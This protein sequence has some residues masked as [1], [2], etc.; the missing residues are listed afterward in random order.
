MLRD[1][2]RELETS[3][4]HKL[5]FILTGTE[6]PELYGAHGYGYTGI[7]EAQP[8]PRPTEA[9]EPVS[10]SNRRRRARG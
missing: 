10:P 2:A 9:A 1:L 6:T 3:S 5:G 4:A 7:D 8:A